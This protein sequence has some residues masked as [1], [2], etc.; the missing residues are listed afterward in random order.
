MNYRGMNQLIPQHSVPLAGME[1]CLVELRELVVR[2]IVIEATGF[3]GTEKLDT[4]EPVLYVFTESALRPI[5]S[6]SRD[7]RIF[8]CLFVSLSV[9]PSHPRNHASRRIR[10]LWSKGVS[11]ILAY[12]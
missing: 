4:L 6:I 9:C 11:L 1:E 7:V 3:F 8:V 2:S 5:Q 12:L 10:D